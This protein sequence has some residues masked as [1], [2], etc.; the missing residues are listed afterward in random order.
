M[1]PRLALAD[2]TCLGSTPEDSDSSEGP[3]HLHFLKLLTGFNAVLG[4]DHCITETGA[5][6]ESGC[7]LI[8][9]AQEQQKEDKTGLQGPAC[10]ELS[11]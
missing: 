5:G 4:E 6:S 11:L 1:W 9:P 3:M 2:C 8:R 10:A 7:Q